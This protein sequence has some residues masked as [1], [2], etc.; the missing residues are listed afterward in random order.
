MMM[1]MPP[2]PDSSAPIVLSLSHFRS[3]LRC[4]KQYELKHVQQLHWPSD[5]QH[6]TLGQS[7]HK[8][9]D[10]QSRNL[11]LDPLLAAQSRADIRQQYNALLQ[12][13]LAQAPIVANEWAFYVPL[14][15]SIENPASSSVPPLP[16]VWVTGRID[17][18]VRHNN[19]V[20]V[21]DWKTGTAIPWQPE[22]ALQT[23]LYL[24]AVGE[25]RSQLQ[26]LGTPLEQ[27]AMA[28]VGFRKGQLHAVQV[29]Y[30][31]A[32][33]QQTRQDLQTWALAMLHQPAYSLPEHCPDAYCPFGQVCGIQATDHAD[34][35]PANNPATFA[36][37]AA[38]SLP[39][40]PAIVLPQAWDALF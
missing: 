32:A 16:P 38:L 26:L 27:L 1:M 36:D 30:S 31:D 40:D 29:A 11:P 19:Q 37:Q 23:R 34:G 2:P 6:F 18:V 17:R 28:Y 21:V 20:V 12:H 8:L 35:D 9:L 7:V 14:S 5:E 22:A 13:P 33:H 3:W 24:F 15:L 10:Y 39:E 4:R 25:C